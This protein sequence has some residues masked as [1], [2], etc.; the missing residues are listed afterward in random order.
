MVDSSISMVT[1]NTVLPN[2]M[3]LP[4]ISDVIQCAPEGMAI[5]QMTQL[6]LDVA[7]AHRRILVHPDDGGLLCF[8]ANGELYRCSIHST[9]ELVQWLVLGALGWHGA[10]LPF[11]AGPW[12]CPVAVCR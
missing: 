3:L 2:H 4:R 1:A 5:Q 12:A 8:H 9:L 10:I 11:I 7:K 6:T